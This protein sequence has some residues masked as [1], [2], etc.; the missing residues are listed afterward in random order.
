MTG[1]IMRWVALSTAVV[2]ASCPGPASLL[3]AQSGGFACP[4]AGVTVTFKV[5]ASGVE[6][7]DSYH[8]A[9]PND[10]MVCLVS[11]A[12]AN[13]GSGEHRLLF[14]YFYFTMDYPGIVESA[15]LRAA[16]QLLFSG[17]KNQVTFT[18]RAYTP[19]S[20]GKGPYR[21]EDTWTRIGH[22]TIKIGNR[23]IGVVLFQQKSTRE[24]DN[25][26]RARLWFDPESGVFVKIEGTGGIIVSYIANF[27][28]EAISIGSAN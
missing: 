1:T 2:V 6:W 8:G 12:T 21:F 19:W 9:D 16:L 25:P 4:K 26:I 22:D 23:D 7:T 24:L 3:R 20:G 11:G 15:K 18:Y 17:Q 13:R 27:T 14:D 28:N 5:P 10:P